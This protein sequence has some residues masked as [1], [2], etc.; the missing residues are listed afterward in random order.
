[1]KNN[2]SRPVFCIILHVLIGVK[3]R[4]APRFFLP[5]TYSPFRP[6]GAT[7]KD[8]QHNPIKEN[9]RLDLDMPYIA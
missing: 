6:R 1:M 9:P 2:S 5:Y 8:M 4:G 3:K 7:L